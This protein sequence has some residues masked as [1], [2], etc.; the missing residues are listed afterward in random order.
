[1]YPLNEI[2]ST[3]TFDDLVRTPGIFCDLCKE[4]IHE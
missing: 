3:G 1:M 2:R 4:R